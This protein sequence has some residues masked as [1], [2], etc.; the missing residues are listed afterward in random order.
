MGPG[1][2]LPP[3]LATHAGGRLGQ[4]FSRNCQVR[5]LSCI[6]TFFETIEILEYPERPG[7]TLFVRGDVRRVDDETPR[8][9]PDAD[10]HRLVSAA[11]RM[12]TTGG[13]RLCLPKRPRTHP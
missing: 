9:I 1:D 2:H 11:E 8:F 7:R 6:K 3:A 10:W 12:T 5:S 4:V 13:R